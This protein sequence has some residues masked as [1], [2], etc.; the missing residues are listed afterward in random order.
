MKSNI[1]KYVW[2][3]FRLAVR[4][5]SANLFV[6][7]NFANELRLCFCITHS[8]HLCDKANKKR[9][10]TH[11]HSRKKEIWTKI[12]S[13]NNLWFW[14]CTI[15]VR[16]NGSGDETLRL[17]ENIEAEKWK[18]IWHHFGYIGQQNERNNLNAY[19]R[20]ECDPLLSNRIKFHYKHLKRD[21]SLRNVLFST[22]T[23]LVICLILLILVMLFAGYCHFKFTRRS[24]RSHMD[25]RILN[26]IL[27]QFLITSQLKRLERLASC[28]CPVSSRLL[29]WYQLLCHFYCGVTTKF[30][31]KWFCH[32]TRTYDY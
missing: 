9:A 25:F 30:M 32:K 1:L 16:R 10:H 28:K 6:R 27:C 19:F 13:Q 22:S 24:I 8:L 23:M 18:G 3:K 26:R 31:G 15:N 14:K 7:S 2:C 29:L 20:R 17:T 11:T 12:V 4:D 21:N 5:S